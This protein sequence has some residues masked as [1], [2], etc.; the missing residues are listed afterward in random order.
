MQDATAGRRVRLRLSLTIFLLL[1]S[2]G[3]S[4]AL[5]ELAYGEVFAAKLIPAV[6]GNTD[7]APLFLSDLSWRSIASATPDPGRVQGRF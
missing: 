6:F 7:P 1:V 5:R 3:G 4:L 2:V